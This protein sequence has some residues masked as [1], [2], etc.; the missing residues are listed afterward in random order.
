MYRSVLL[1]VTMMSFLVS[2][3]YAADLPQPAKAA[4]DEAVTAIEK[5]YPKKEEWKK[6]PA[7]FTYSVASAELGKVEEKKEITPWK[8]VYCVRIAP[9]IATFSDSK[10][11]HFIVYN[12]EGNLWKAEEAQKEAFLRL[13]C[14]NWAEPK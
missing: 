9:M 8:Q 12:E 7:P 2:H 3:A 6:E 14:T 4:L 1:S 13:S 5:S 10:I 11:G